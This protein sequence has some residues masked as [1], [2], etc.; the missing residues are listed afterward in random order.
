MVVVSFVRLVVRVVV[1]MSVRVC[2]YV[3][4]CCVCA[5]ACAVV[6]LRC[7]AYLFVRVH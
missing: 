3:K 6:R 5:F 2:V 7:C 1:C 4:L